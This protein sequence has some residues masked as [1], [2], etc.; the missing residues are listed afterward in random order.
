[1]AG[2]IPPKPP[3][4]PSAKAREPQATRAAE[5]PR[6]APVQET[7]GWVA[8]SSKTRSDPAR[9][10]QLL[11]DNARVLEAARKTSEKI[12]AAIASNEPLVRQ[13]RKDLG[14]KP[15]PEGSRPP[16]VEETQE[17][18]RQALERNAELLK[19]KR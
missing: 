13:A 5:R 19:P 11:A 10:D 16:T 7:R 2:K 9:L 17:R 14:M 15:D 8:G 18:I 4:S 1:M 3:P 12:D 6:E